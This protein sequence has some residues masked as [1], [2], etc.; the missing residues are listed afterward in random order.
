MIVLIDSRAWVDFFE[1]SKSGAQVREY[2]MDEDLEII[3]SS[4]N[5]AEIYRI[6]LDR[7]DE[8]AAEKRRRSMLSRCFLMAL[9]YFLWL[10][11]SCSVVSVVSSS[12]CVLCALCVSVVKTSLATGYGR[13]RLPP[14]RHRGL[15]ETKSQLPTVKSEEPF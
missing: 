7:F 10:N 2:V 11:R 15:T 4:I 13:C 14:Q 1:G 9:R 5:L 6:A 3:V 12:L 8:A